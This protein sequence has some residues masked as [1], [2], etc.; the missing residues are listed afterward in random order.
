VLVENMTM[1]V[2]TNKEYFYRY[3]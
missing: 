2:V 1:P 3:Q